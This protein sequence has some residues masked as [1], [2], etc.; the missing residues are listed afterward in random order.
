LIRRLNFTSR[1]RIARGDVTVRL[2]TI[3]D[4]RARLVAAFDLEKYGL[5]PSARLFV[6][7]YRQT[8]WQRFDYGT[9]ADPVAAE[10]TVLQDFG[11]AQGVRFRVRVVERTGNGG[12]PRV[13]A[14]VDDLRPV[15]PPEGK[16]GLSLLP[17]EWGEFE[18]HTWKL[19]VDEE[20]GPLLRISRKLVP[21]RE[22][23]VGS[24]EFV[25]LVLPVVLQRTLG[26]A[27]LLAGDAEDSADAGWAA[28]WLQLAKGLTG[29]GPPPERAAGASLSD[30]EEDWIDDVVEAFSKHHGIAERFAAWWSTAPS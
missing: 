7:A 8:S 14:L 15:A 13:L 24:R 26:Q 10:P 22:A 19:E 29:V 30:E 23:F 28:D 12:A 9:V 2:T 27:V 17:I 21:D 25:S 1:R 4:G 11:T 20:S 3:A 18:G 16:G 5:P 6:E